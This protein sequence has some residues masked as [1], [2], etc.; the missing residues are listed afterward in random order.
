MHCTDVER[1]FFVAGG[2]TKKTQKK[3]KGENMELK[4]CL[5]FNDDDFELEIVEPVEGID[6]MIEECFPLSWDVVSLCRVAVERYVL[7][8]S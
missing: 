7:S 4:S 5:A 6:E 2:K 8:L 1:F 3:M